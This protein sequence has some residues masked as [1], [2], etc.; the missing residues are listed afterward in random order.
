VTFNSL[1]YA[2]FLPVTLLLYWTLPH[3]LRIGGRQLPT[4]QLWLL[5][6]SYAFYWAGAGWFLAMLVFTTVVDY[7]VGRFL[8]RTEGESHRRWILAISLAVN[9]GALGFF[10]YSG[11]FVE[12]FDELLGKAGL[13]PGLPIL[14]V[15]LPIG[16]SFYTF[17]S[18]AYVVDVY[19]RDI[20]A[21]DDLVDFA[22]FVAFFPQLVAGPISRAKA[23]V[24]QLRKERQRPDGAQV[25]SGLMLMLLGLLK[26][27]VVADSL[28]P[29]VNQAFD[30]KHQGTSVALAG[31]I[32]F[33]FQIYADFSGYTDIA[34]GSARLL[35]VELIHNFRQPY[36]S[37]SVTEF[38]RRWHISLSN[39]LRDYLYIPLG[40]NRGGRWRTYRNLMVTMLLG[41]L[42]HGA[43]WPFIIW[44]GL[45][46]LYLAIERARGVRPPP[47]PDTGAGGEVPRRPRQV[48]A[49]AWTFALVCF[50]WVFFRSPT[51]ADALGVLRGVFDI[52]GATLPGND[53]VLFMT[54][55][56]GM[57]V[58]DLLTIRITH[59]VDT[60]RR[61]PVLT[62]AAVG[63]S[64]ALVV[65][66]SG[67]TPV[68][69]I[70]FQ[71]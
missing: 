4:R 55:V 63:L 35:N 42:W 28:A 45:H 34:R 43:G 22:T 2:L 44:G 33:A 18:I 66:F 14:R 26:K 17:Q 25:T 50:A 9:L 41:G 29:M 58:I 53:L 69:F 10:K 47:A 71:F 59:P 48:A 54:M 3:R 40:G 7:N 19:R 68:P 13:S 21:C 31:I 30:G 32:G 5:L 15:A 24:P 23:L 1:Q 39:W 11:F 49:A 60:L 70:Y 6:A 20:E 8:E 65:L 36:L 62:G 27:V 46:G 51:V 67:R 52:N 56:A 16:I 12:Q 57:V 38:W 37:R 64:I 61:R